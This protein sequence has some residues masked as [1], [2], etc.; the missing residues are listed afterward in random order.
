MHGVITVGAKL[1]PDGKE[2]TVHRAAPDTGRLRTPRRLCLIVGASAGQLA[3]GFAS[4]LST[5]N[6]S[7]KAANSA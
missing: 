7:R 4:L 3:D 5:F 1:I 6:R 2:I